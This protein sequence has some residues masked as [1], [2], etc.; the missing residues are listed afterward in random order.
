MAELITTELFCSYYI[1]RETKD[2]VFFA[3]QIQ[4]DNLLV[5]WFKLVSALIYFKEI[6]RY[7]NSEAKENSFI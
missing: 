2:A 3:T 4:P 1:S 5:G 6:R 7:L